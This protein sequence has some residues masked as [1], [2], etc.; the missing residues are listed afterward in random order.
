MKGR[1]MKKIQIITGVVTVLA[2]TVV[3][4]M[5]V[6]HLIRLEPPIV[7]PKA[8]SAK[9]IHIEN[10]ERFQSSIIPV[11]IEIVEIQTIE[12]IV[13]LLYDIPLSDGDQLLIRDISNQFGIDYELLLAIIK[14]ESEFKPNDVG[15]NGNS[16]GILQ[17]QPQW[18][19]SNF[20]A[21]EC[22]DWFDIRDNVTVGC[23]ILQYLYQHYGETIKVLN[24][25]NSNKP[26]NFNG[27][28]D[29][30]ISNLV[31]IHN[32]KR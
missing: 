13:S 27:Y 25:Y 9:E 20:N 6:I 2:I 23:S 31:E 21:Y 14:T 24:A 19:T 7:E 18:W 12:P 15:D 28:S 10:L 3:S 30:V 29:S 11:D 26:N 8:I 22:K 4:A 5:I 32:L 16:L 1:Q 17:V